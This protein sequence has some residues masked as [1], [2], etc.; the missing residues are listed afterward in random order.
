MAATAW[1]PG[2]QAAKIT[3]TWGLNK[4]KKSYDDWQQKLT[5]VD[6]LLL[7]F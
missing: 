3:W 5:H 7:V 1:W 2:L 6:S 4:K